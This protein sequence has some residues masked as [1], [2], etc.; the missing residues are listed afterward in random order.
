MPFSHDSEARHL[1]RF[2]ALLGTRARLLRVLLPGLICLFLGALYWATLA[3]GLTWA[4]DGADGGDLITAAATGGVPHPSGYPTYLLLASAFLRIPLGS[5]AYR[6]NLLSAVCTV[7]AALVIYA[8]V[9]SVD[10]SDVSAS[11][12][13]LAFGTF[14]LVWSQAIITEVYALHGLFVALLLRFSLLPRKNSVD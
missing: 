2:T 7:A 9:R 5:L 8:T 13:S 14:P 10:K 12:A 4:F 3:P 11:I 6:T 1:P